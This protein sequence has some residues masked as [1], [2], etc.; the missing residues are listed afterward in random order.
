[1]GHCFCKPPCIDSFS[2]LHIGGCSTGPLCTLLVVISPAAGWAMTPGTSLIIASSLQRKAKSQQSSRNLP[3]FR[4]ATMSASQDSDSGSLLPSH[5]HWHPQGISTCSSG[6]Q[7]PST[8][9]LML[10]FPSPFISRH[11]PCKLPEGFSVNSLAAKI[12]Q[13]CAQPFTHILSIYICLILIPKA[14]HRN[15]HKTVIHKHIYISLL[16]TQ[17]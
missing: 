5:P 17:H 10:A 3:L 15:T 2:C 7:L 14:E 8:E 4:E 11:L 1:M 6:S 12:A 9:Q 16:W 13:F